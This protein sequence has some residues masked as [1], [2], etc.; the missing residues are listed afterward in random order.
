MYHYQKIVLHWTVFPR[1]MA[2]FLISSG[3]APITH[4]TKHEVQDQFIQFQ[5]D[6]YFQNRKD[7]YFHVGYAK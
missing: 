7:M 5:L 3:L 2:V 1:T 6:I 4:C